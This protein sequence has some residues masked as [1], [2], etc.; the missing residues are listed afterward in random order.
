MREGI[1][2]FFFFFSSLKTPTKQK[3]FT[4]PG[5]FSEGKSFRKALHG[6][7][8]W[9]WRAGLRR[10]PAG[11]EQSLAPGQRALPPAAPPAE[12]LPSHPVTPGETGRRRAWADVAGEVGGWGGGGGRNKGKEGKLNVSERRAGAAKG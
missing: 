4:L 6:T 12:A 3:S 1:F 9:G 8:S 11:A 5:R 2:F 7:A 10:S